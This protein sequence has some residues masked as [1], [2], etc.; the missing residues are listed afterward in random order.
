MSCKV[1]QT[2]GFLKR[3]FE[4]KYS[5]KVLYCSLVCFLLE[6]SHILWDPYTTSDFLILDWVQWYS[7]FFIS[8]ILNINHPFNNYIPDLQVGLAILTD[9]KLKFLQ[10]RIDSTYD[11]P[12]ILSYIYICMYSNAP[13]SL[14]F[15]LSSY[16][17]FPTMTKIILLTA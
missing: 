17:V 7:L 12:S 11:A 16:Y 14:F 3:V 2:F 13:L 8:H 10:I 6:Y 1:Y 5:S 9:A 15:H 4:V